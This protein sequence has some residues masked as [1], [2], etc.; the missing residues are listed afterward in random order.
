MTVFDDNLR[1]T[2]LVMSE[3]RVNDEIAPEMFKLFYYIKDD[4]RPQQI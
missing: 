3:N 2:L 4:S 1:S